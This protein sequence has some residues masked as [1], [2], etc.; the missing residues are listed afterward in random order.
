VS[1]SEFR[2]KIK[3]QKW[4]KYAITLL[5]FLV[6]YLF[7]GDQSMIQFIRRGREIRRLEEQREMYQAGTQK[8][9][10]EMQTLN[11]PDSLEQY[12]REH[13][14]MHTANEDIYLVEED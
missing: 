13:Y 6:V 1:F 2:E 8:A 10:R 9:Q 14:Y 5:V 3:L 7:I 4:G 12:A 11:S